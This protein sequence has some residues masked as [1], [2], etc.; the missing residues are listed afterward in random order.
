MNFSFFFKKNLL[1][2][3]R[4]CI[5]VL[6][7]R[8]YH[9]S[10][11]LLISYTIPR[12]STESEI[13]P[14][15]LENGSD[16]VS[17]DI[18]EQETQK[19]SILDKI[20]L[21]Q[22]KV[23]EEGSASILYQPDNVFYNPI[24]QYNRDLSILSINAW[25]EIYAT[26]RIEKKLKKLSNRKSTNVENGSNKKQKLDSTGESSEK[27]TTQETQADEVSKTKEEEEE[28]I[29]K[30]ELRPFANI[31]EALSASGLRAIRYGKEIPL[32][33]KVV[34]NDL[35]KE[36][37]ESINMNIEYNKL[38]GKVIGNE[39][40]A[41]NYMHNNTNKFHVVD[42]DPYGTAAPFIDSAINS[43]KDDGLLLVTCTDLGVLAGNGYPEKCFALYGGTNVWN[44]A[45]HE[46]ALRLVL[47]MISRTAAKYKK[48]I[49]PQLSLSIDFYVRLF[50]RVRTSPIKVKELASE[51]MITY[52]CSGCSSTHNQYLG[53]VVENPNGKTKQ[54]NK[55][56]G[57]AKGPPI[58][59]NCP[60][61]NYINHVTGPMWGGNLHNH[62]FIDKVLELQSKA[63]DKI[64]KTLPRIKGMLTMAKQE[65]QGHDTSFYF[66]TTTLSSILRCQAPPIEKLASALG[67]LGYES[68][69]THAMAACIKTNAPMEVVWFVGKKWCL[70]DETFKM[71]RLK[72]TT[73]GYRIMNNE[74][75]GKNIN[76]SEIMKEK[77]VYDEYKGDELKWLF[78]SNEH[79]E[80]I[81]RIRKIKIVKFQENPT[82]NW[83]PKSAPKVRPDKK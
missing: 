18:S 23:Q 63:D 39:G 30:I 38:T 16:V 77:N 7:T 79:S 28:E 21:T 14:V 82:K 34:A 76:L 22:Y 41:I 13:K 9:T 60:Y 35:S 43:I 15:A 64:Y 44:D 47:G 4:N 75:I 80:K 12:M 29:K 53:K 58:G 31:L 10:L 24:Q 5:K 8:N 56:Y 11:P 6:D 48:Y 3:S 40:D 1:I 37:V 52:L 61:C 83:G 70:A 45:T 62:E 81:K 26:E 42:L 73:A 67:N 49:E 25:N 66:K 20:D 50:I 51:T 69:L 46:S 2:G 74:E 65:L 54:N 72:E 78:A 27:V 33:E 71:D 32:A 36:A 68:S 59:S 57:L 55:K 17:N 19:D